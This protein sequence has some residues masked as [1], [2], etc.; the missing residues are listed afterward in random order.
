MKHIDNLG[1]AYDK[2][3]KEGGFSY[4]LHRDYTD[5][6]I[7]KINHYG[8]YCLS[9]VGKDKFKEVI[10]IFMTVNLPDLDKENNFLMS[11]MSEDKKYFTID[12]YSTTDVESLAEISKEVTGIEYIDTEA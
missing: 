1:Q 4:S 9:S 3:M 8:D 2:L 12:V 5:R 10:G 11:V 6:Y 7:T